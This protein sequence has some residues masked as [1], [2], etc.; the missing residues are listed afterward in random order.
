MLNFN[1]LLCYGKL[2]RQACVRIM[3]DENIEIAGFLAPN[4]V[5]AEERTR[6]RSDVEVNCR[7][8]SGLQRNL[9]EAFQLA[10]RARLPTTSRM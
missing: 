4:I 8:F 1:E 5:C 2:A 7:R 9:P 3:P 6:L 10:V